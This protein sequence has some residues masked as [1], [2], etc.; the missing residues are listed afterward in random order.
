MLT[1]RPSVPDDW[2]SV[3]LLLIDAGLP[4]E[5][6]GPALLE[7][8][9]IAESEDCEA[10]ESVIGAVGLQVFD[11]IGLLRSLVVT[12]SARKSGIGGKLLGALEAAAQVAGIGELWLL[13]IDADAFFTRQDYEI[14]PR[15]QA[16][17]SI[18]Q[19]EEFRELCPG[20]AF[21][22]VKSLLGTGARQD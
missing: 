19:T 7:G 8:F 20:D 14:A 11:N 21:L 3:R 1:L 12:K 13:T 6:L 10:G 2:N 22:M 18:R 5:D 17:D 15:D 4:V 16:P 9:L